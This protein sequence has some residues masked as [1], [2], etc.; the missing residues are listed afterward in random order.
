MT[1]YAVIM[2]GGSGTRL[3]P[4]SRQ[5]RPKQTLTLVDQRT[6]FQ[7]AVDRLAP[8]FPPE[9]I[10]VVTRRQHAALLMAQT[11]ELPP[12]NF[13]VEPEGRGTAP[14]IGLAALHLSDIDSEASMA[15]LTADH[16]IADRDGFLQVLRAAEQIAAVGY[17][18]T[19]GIRPAA[20]ATGYG[21]IQHGERLAES[22]DQNAF[23]VK[24]FVEKP[25]RD[26]AQAMVDSGA[27]S[28]NSGMFIWRVDRILQ[29]I[30]LHMPELQRQLFRHV[31][32]NLL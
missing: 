30:G 20:P 29:E 23:C 13:I 14:A 25:D 6:L 22:V 32:S 11:P 16:H 21:Y 18:V 8:L 5:H 26:Q 15:V 12:E 17:L 24:R 2:A 31:Q 28:W 7:H 9:R 10:L 27:Y 19:L 4:L 1:N 3:W